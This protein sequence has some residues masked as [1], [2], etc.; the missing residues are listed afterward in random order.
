MV[1]QR[2]AVVMN[3]L[4]KAAFSSEFV[5]T[6]MCGAVAPPGGHPQKLQ[7]RV[8]GLRGAKLGFRVRD[9]EFESSSA[10][11]KYI[12]GHSLNSTLTLHPPPPTITIPGVAVTI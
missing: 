1:N 2:I 6:F 3:F 4:I 10:R 9:N 12:T 11:Y 8:A 5:S 7:H